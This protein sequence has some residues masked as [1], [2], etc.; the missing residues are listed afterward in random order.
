MDPFQ[1]I[2]A[3]GR[4]LDD[5]SDMSRAGRAIGDGVGQGD[6]DAATGRR[7][8]FTERDPHTGLNRYSRRDIRRP[9]DLQR[10]RSIGLSRIECSSC[11]AVLDNGVCHHDQRCLA[12]PRDEGR[13]WRRTTGP[14]AVDE[15]SK[16]VGWE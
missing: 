11:H 5:P 7:G 16:D 3:R 1:V 10:S 13:W 15:T 4:I 14:M 6:H 9:R 2:K 12:D 8:S